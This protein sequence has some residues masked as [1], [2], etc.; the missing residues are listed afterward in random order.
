LATT[1][2]LV[3]CAS[4]AGDAQPAVIVQGPEGS[5]A[6]VDV[7][8]IITDLLQ[9][10]EG[11]VALQPTWG[12]DG[13]AVW[14][15]LSGGDAEVAIL[16]AGAVNR[17]QSGR[18]PFYYSWSP[19]GKKLAHLGS[20]VPGIIGLTLMDAE[21]G[22]ATDLDQGGPYYFDWAPSSERLL[23]NIGSRQLALVEVGG[24]KTDLEVTVAPFQA[25]EWI[26]DH[27]AL[28]VIRRAVDGTAGLGAMA[29][30]QLDVD[31]LAVIG[32]DGSIVR[33]LAT[34]RGSAA[35]TVDHEH[36]RVAYTDTI[37]RMTYSRG[38]LYV[39]PL[40]GGDPQQISDLEV[41]AHQWS[42]DGN[43]LLYMSFVEDIR[44]L[45]PHVWEDGV[46]TSFESFVPTATFI[47]AYL[48]FWDQYTRSLTL[49][50]P[51]SASFV[52]PSIDGVMT[53][54]VAD[55]SPEVLAEG[56]FAAWSIAAG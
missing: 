51:D 43:R 9:E 40:E 16:R 14:T 7:A 13:Q 53:Q 49:W 36:D 12:P 42:P 30:G 28:V 24:A 31:A 27:E 44:G 15:E 48:P 29:A 1:L 52:Y 6:T 47:E 4:S 18:A 19:D 56:E 23:A 2:A 17:Y 10:G 35:F 8:G 39:V 45:A 55:G 26:D 3:A 5:L 34:L 33:E 54:Q 11:K 32:D 41:V 37:G 21:G 20:E 50:A 25:P 38:P 46:D 22:A